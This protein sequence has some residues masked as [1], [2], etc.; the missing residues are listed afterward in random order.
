MRIY[1]LKSNRLQAFPLARDYIGAEIEAKDEP[2]L[3]E[4]END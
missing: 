2:L 1:S 4:V 3:I